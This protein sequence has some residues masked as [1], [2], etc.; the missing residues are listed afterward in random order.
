MDSKEIQ[1]D[2]KVLEGKSEDNILGSS[3]SVREPK[4]AASLAKLNDLKEK[5]PD[6]KEIVISRNINLIKEVNDKADAYWITSMPTGKYKTID[7]LSLTK[8]SGVVR[9]QIERNPNDKYLIL[10]Q[11]IDNLAELNG[12]KSMYSLISSL[13]DVVAAKGNAVML[14]QYNANGLDSKENGL[15]DSILKDADDLSRELKN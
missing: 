5:Y 8:M 1:D 6:A 9:D 2:N 3:Y 13:T 14:V 15:L 12:F 10:F 7:I 11:G 4:Y